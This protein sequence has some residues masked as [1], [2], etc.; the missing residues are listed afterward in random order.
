MLVVI[1]QIF[2]SRS[3]VAAGNCALELSDPTGQRTKAFA[4]TYRVVQDKSQERFSTLRM[5]KLRKY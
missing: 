5:A 1:K 3:A 2:F 4:F